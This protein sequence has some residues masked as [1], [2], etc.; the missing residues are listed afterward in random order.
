MLVALRDEVGD[1]VFFETL[2]TYAERFSDGNATTEDFI[3]VAEE[4]A[5]RD[6]GNLFSTWLYDEQIPA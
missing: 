1:D 4:I 2:R 6:L 5:G 3:S